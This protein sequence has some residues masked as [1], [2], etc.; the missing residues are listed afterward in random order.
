M[1]TDHEA[2]QDTATRPSGLKR[3]AVIAA[4]ITAGLIAGIGITLATT[5]SD[6]SA[7]Q[8]PEPA[9]HSQ[10][11]LEDRL[12][13]LGRGGANASELEDSTEDADAKD[14]PQLTAC[15]TAIDHADDLIGVYHD[16]LD[17][18]AE[19]IMAAGSSDGERLGELVEDLDELTGAMLDLDPEYMD[20]SQQCRGES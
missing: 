8:Q 9:Q 6:S 10:M 3:C 14:D 1:T 17:V 11:S 2:T 13:Y 19:G 18:S 15:L 20:A 16:A 5:S 12:V 7:D 4:S